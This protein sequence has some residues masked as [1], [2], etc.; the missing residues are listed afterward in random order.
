M[1]NL[2][3]E[4][5]FKCYETQDPYLDLGMCGLT[6]KDFEAGSPLDI[7]LRKC[8]HLECL[9]LSNSWDEWDEGGKVLEDQYS[10]NYSH[11]ES[12][13]NY[14]NSSLPSAFLELHSLKKLICCGDNI[15][16]WC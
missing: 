15:G 11:Y 5:T 13:M 12:R 2:A 9:I 6:D 4:L 8:T 16:S 14:F 7:A 3:L 1:N 10:R